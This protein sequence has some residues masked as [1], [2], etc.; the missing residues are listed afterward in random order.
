MQP[1]GEGWN[2]HRETHPAG[3]RPGGAVRAGAD[4]NPVGERCERGERDPTDIE[5]HGGERQRP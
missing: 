2:P 4:Q 3:L 5:R 1:H